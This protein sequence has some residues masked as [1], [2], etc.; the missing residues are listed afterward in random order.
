MLTEDKN[1]TRRR[2]LQLVGVGSAGVVLSGCSGS[3]GDN[4]TGG[5]TP[6]TTTPST[7]TTGATT[8]PTNPDCVLTPSAI[9]GPFYSDLDLIRQDI[10]DGKPGARLRLNITVIDVS[11][12]EPIPSANVDVW[13]ADA[14]GLYSAFSGQGDAGNIDTSTESFLRGVQTTSGDGVATFDSIYPGWYMGRTTHI[15]LKVIFEDRTQVT[16]QLFFPDN[17]STEVYREQAYLSRGAKDTT[18]G[19]DTFGGDDSR[20]LMSVSRQGE[21]YTA[22]HTIG[23]NRA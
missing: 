22:S 23:I 8:P 2:F 11:R 20:L 13:H 14:G 1:A 19:A 6:T 5:A 4:A 16:T 18:N 17:I 7:T 21:L 10:T 9:E 15:H 3:G 12:C